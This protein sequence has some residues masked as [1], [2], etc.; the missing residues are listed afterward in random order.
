[1]AVATG[2]AGCSSHAISGCCRVFAARV[3]AVH[4]RAWTG[5]L[6]FQ[7]QRK[8][9]VLVVVGAQRDSCVWVCGCGLLFL[10]LPAPTAHVAPL[11]TRGV[12]LLHQPQQVLTVLC[13]RGAQGAAA[14][15]VGAFW[16]VVPSWMLLVCV[17]RV[18][19]PCVSYPLAQRA[20]NSDDELRTVFM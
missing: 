9:C 18:V 1:M 17:V 2:A 11:G 3:G 8:L 4:P 6:V 7:H 15:W 12:A 14:A 19:Q 13:W 10:Q 5:R 16:S 20:L